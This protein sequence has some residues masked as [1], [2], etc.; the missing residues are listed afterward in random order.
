MSTASQGS[1]T[2]EMKQSYDD[3]GF[4]VVERL[5]SAEELVEVRQQIDALI[6]DPDNPPEGVT[7]GREG[8]TNPQTKGTGDVR[9]A[10]FMVRF[11][12][13]FQDFARTPKLLECVRGLLGPRVKVF[14]DQMLLKPPGGQAKPLHQDQSYFQVSPED[15]LVT[16]WIAL[17]EATLENGCMTY[18]PGSHKHSIFPIGNDP[19]RPIHHIP[20]TGDLDLPDPVHCPVPVG[21]LI[22]HHG[23]ALHASA[24]NNSTS[25]RKA[26]IFHFATSDSSSARDELNQQ[27]SLEI[28]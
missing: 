21:S 12:P 25:W 16:A 4:L 2:P 3:N 9:G 17:D 15:D 27:V 24:D 22:F 23:C 8:D 11:V 28:D 19:E 10:A 7:I 5:F 6:A 26:L 20:D 14:R 1:F 13:C 18:V